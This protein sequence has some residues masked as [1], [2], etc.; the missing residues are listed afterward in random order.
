METMIDW[1][2]DTWGGTVH[3]AANGSWVTDKHTYDAD[4]QG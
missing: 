1:E 4:G 3:L 2:S